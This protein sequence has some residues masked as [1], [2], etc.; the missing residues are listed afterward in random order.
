MTEIL[1]ATA[2]AALMAAGAVGPALAG[3]TYENASGGSFTFYGQFN[4]SYLS[5]DDGVNSHNEIVD[6]VNSNS[7]VGFY[8]RQPVGA[9]KFQFRF[10][11]G[12]GF[13]SSSAV[14]QTSTPKNVN[15]DRTDLRHVD[16]SLSGAYGTISAG[17][18]SMASDGIGTSDLSGTTVVMGESIVYAGGGYQLTTSAGALSGIKL[19]D[20]FA[21]FDGGRKGRIRYDS[22]DWNGFVLSTSYGTEV[23]KAGVDD[24]Y[25]DVTLRYGK[26]F[27]DLK[28][29]SALGVAWTD[30]ATGTDTRD[31]VAS[32][33]LEHT[34][35]L[36]GVL[37]YGARDTSGDYYYA[38]LGY[39][40][41]VLSIGATAVS[42]D[43]YSGDDLVSA[44]SD[45]ESWGVGV[46]Q[47]IDAY[48]VE[49]YAS[50]RDLSFSDTSGTTYN[51]ASAVLFGARWKF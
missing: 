36:N 10:E 35:G 17:Q 48:N 40:M 33:A 49:A 34:S 5:V 29:E 41:N 46:V 19:S 20:A 8:L 50:Y 47:K 1:R 39:K 32:V 45:S 31:T 42:A 6:N 15:W 22:P 37:S 2:A 12:F 13:K 9:S 23:L 38:K 3:P 51:D 16:F 30:K 44:G 7:R 21:S 27:G 28:L 4:P 18:G 25:Y 14:G 24:D 11:T 43:Y 26:D